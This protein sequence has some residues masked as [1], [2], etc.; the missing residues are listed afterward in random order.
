[1]NSF[2]FFIIL[3]YVKPEKIGNAFPSREFELLVAALY[4]NSLK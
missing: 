2:H 4:A 3:L 1:M